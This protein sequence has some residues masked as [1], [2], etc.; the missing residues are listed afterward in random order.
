VNA[1]ATFSNTRSF[2][3]PLNDWNTSQVT[4][5]YQAFGFT[6]RFNQPLDQWDISRVT[7]MS[8]MFQNAAAFAQ[9]L[10]MWDVR[11]VAGFGVMFT[12]SRMSA[13]AVSG[14]PGF[15]RACR[16]H[17]S[18]KEQNAGWNPVFAGLVAD[19]AE[20]ERSLCTPYLAGGALQGDPHLGLAHGG[21]ADFRG[22]DGCLFNFLSTR[23]VTVNA[24][25]RESTFALQGSEV[26]GTFVTEVHVAT[27]DRATGTWFKVSY[28]AEEVGEGNWGW[29]AV[30]GSCGAQSFPLH[31]HSTRACGA[32]GATT[33]HSSAVFAL[34]EWEVSVQSRPVFDRIEGPKHRLDLSLR[35]LLPEGLL[36]EWPH[37]LIGQSFDGDARPRQG[38]QDDYSTPVVWT[39]AQA[40]G[41]IEGVADDYRM[42]SPFATAFRFSRFDPLAEGKRGPAPMPN[43]AWAPNPEAAPGF[44]TAGDV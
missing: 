25:L 7:T 23:D 35:P 6:D 17:H 15:G 38:K 43:S 5:M 16:I 32:S 33:T 39:T 10:D 37:G 42:A 13:E 28:W 26:H 27:L 8:R 40:E 12:A 3:Q 18:W 1:Q 41:A 36:A 29:G 2:D 11:N 30:N 24:Q 9:E 4:N 20:L 14:G 34:P 22:C 44:A 21:H 19:A 31:P